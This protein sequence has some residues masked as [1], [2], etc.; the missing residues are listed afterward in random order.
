MWEIVDHLRK[1]SYSLGRIQDIVS[2]GLIAQHGTDEDRAKVVEYL[3]G[4]FEAFQRR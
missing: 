3:R 2:L 1:I 4:Q